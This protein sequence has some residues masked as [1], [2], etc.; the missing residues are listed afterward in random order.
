MREEGARGNIICEDTQHGEQQISWTPPPSSF[1]R[2]SSRKKLIMEH[3]DLYQGKQLLDELAR[4]I[5]VAGCIP[6]KELFEAIEVGV[7]I[8][9]HFSDHTGRLEYP[10]IVDAC[11]GHGLLA[12]VLLLLSYPTPESNNT[13]LQA[14]FCVDRTKP[15]SARILEDVLLAKWPHLAPRMRFV[16]GDLQNI[17]P[18]R[19]TLLVS[20]HACGD[21]SDALIRFAADSQSALALI[22]CCHETRLFQQNLICLEKKLPKVGRLAETSLYEDLSTPELV[23]IMDSRRVEKL[24]V[25]GF[26]VK[27]EHIS[28]DITPKN[29]LI[30]A[31]YA[32]NGAARSDASNSGDTSNRDVASLSCTPANNESNGGTAFLNDI[33]PEVPFEP[34]QIPDSPWTW[35]RTN[36]R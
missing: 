20:V 2:W 33:V 28:S 11:S 18:N 12:W 8:H 14:A 10:F 6:R 19:G 34:R 7:R 25:S 29:L 15:P 24:R 21:L 22:P 30:L 1:H 32:N 26:H 35:Y 9:E 13:A 3:Y 16:E 23:G 4:T 17:R 31:I 36:S 27:E 5:C